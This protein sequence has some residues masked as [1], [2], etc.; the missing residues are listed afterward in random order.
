METIFEK[1]NGIKGNTIIT[2]KYKSNVKMNKGGR[3]QANVLYGRD[4]YRVVD[5]QLQ[6]G[7]SYEN[8]VNNR[9]EKEQGCEMGFETESLK[10]FKW[11]K[12]P[13]FM[14][15]LKSGEMYVRF[16]KMKNSQVNKKEVFV[17]GH[18]ADSDEMAIIKEYEIVNHFYSRKQ[19]ESGL[20]ENQVECRNIKLDNIMEII[21]KGEMVTK[22]S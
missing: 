14:E 1:L 13:Y 3:V 22:E 7:N 4:V 6:F 12:Y 11:V 18:K 15:S 20:T 5:T 21:I 8:S 9:A 16:Y 2:I 19:A 17:D 10:G